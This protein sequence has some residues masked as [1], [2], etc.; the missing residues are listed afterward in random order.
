MEFWNLYDYKGNKK[1]KIAIRGTKL[2]DD[3]FHLVVN[4][5]IINDKGEFLITQ[6][7]KT[8]THA[9]MWECTGG[10]AMIG[11]NSLQAAIREVKEELGIDI[12][13]NDAIFIGE[14]RRYFKSCPDIL[15]VWLFKSN[16]EL[17]DIKIQEEEV[18]DVMWASSS[19]IANLLKNHKFEANS[20]IDKVININNDNI[21]C[22]V[23]FN[24]TN[25]ICNEN[26]IN[27]S[28]T[29]NP[30]KEKGNIY[31]TG[32][33]IKNQNDTDF[34]Y[35]YKA[36]II[37]TMNDTFQKNK[38]STFL[39]FNKKIKE[40]LKDEKKFHILGEQNYDLINKLN[41]K[42]YT[43]ELI[44]DEVPS[45]NAKWIS[46]KIDYD[47]AKK[48]ITSKKIVIQ[49]RNGS[50]GN[51]TF[52]IDNKEKFEKYSAYCN[53]EYYLSK[54]IEHLPI[55]ITV[56][57]SKYNDI[58]LPSSVQLIKLEDDMF[59]Y[60]GADFIY[61]QNFNSKIK[62]Q[63]EEYTTIIIKKLK[64]LNYKGIFGIDYIIDNR[65]NVYFMEIN[66]R[67]QSSSFLINKY[68]SK[69][70]YTSLAELHYLAITDNYIGNTYLDKIDNSFINC[71]NT[72]DYQ[73]FKYYKTIKNGYFH[74]N[75]SS[76][77]R[78]IYNYSLIKNSCFQ[79]RKIDK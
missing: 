26:F 10:S 68:L 34:L 55:N 15:H 53:N 22:Y 24:G 74:K 37:K 40:L 43:R 52:Y 51:N 61:S 8:K 16:V 31:Y 48:I 58:I 79:K 54:Y 76:Y 65:D 21:I 6:R 64:K 32:N 20:F 13:E 28:I 5:W 47:T 44:N 23:G 49:G 12:L 30:T 18:N 46:K 1:N 3:D 41:D 19:K 27:N 7:T 78:K 69:Y 73:E 14:T 36:Y 29:I 67:F 2:N 17:K 45:I 70:C 50:G 57:I 60:L 71:K 25:A 72:K 59:K 63:V 35:K 38:N 66:P 33:S 56:V 77:F 42:K 11:E 39:V 9:L 75:K 62:K 4:A